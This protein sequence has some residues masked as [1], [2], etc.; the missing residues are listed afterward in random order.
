MPFTQEEEKELKEK[1]E[2]EVKKSKEKDVIGQT[3]NKPYVVISLVMTLIVIVAIIFLEILSPEGKD[4]SGTITLIIGLS[5]TFTGTMLTLLKNAET[6]VMINNR[7][8]Q[9]M[10]SNSRAERAE[11]EKAGRISAN[12][13]TDELAKNTVPVV[14]PPVSE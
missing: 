13:R 9:W 8:S 7:L 1:W 11:G 3:S 14:E 4:T 10:E 5:A 2:N 6:H 12:A